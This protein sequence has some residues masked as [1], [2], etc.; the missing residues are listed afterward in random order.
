M[1]SLGLRETE[2]LISGIGWIL[3]NCAALGGN[4]LFA[5]R[6]W[7]RLGRKFELIAAGVRIEK[8]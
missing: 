7:W 4:V 5:M 2:S 3:P 1:R 8:L 6:K